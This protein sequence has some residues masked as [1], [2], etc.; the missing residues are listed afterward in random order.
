[1]TIE[2]GMWLLGALF[3]IVS[4]ISGWLCLEVVAMKSSLRSV[5]TSASLNKEETERR[6]NEHKENQKEAVESFTRLVHRIEDG[7]TAVHKRLDSLFET[8]R[9][10]R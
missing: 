2:M 9:G 4:G 7:V 3:L 6:F 10:Q 5:E 1:M 8:L